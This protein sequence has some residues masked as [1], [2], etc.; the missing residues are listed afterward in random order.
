MLHM[1]KN[2]DA[3]MEQSI[4]YVR[5][6]INKKKQ[7]LIE[8]T[9]MDGS[10]DFPKP[11]KLLHLSCLKVF[12]MFF[13]ASNRFDSDTDLHDDIS[14]AIYIPLQVQS[15]KSLQKSLPLPSVSR[16]KSHGITSYKDFS[17]PTKC[18]VNRRLLVHQLS[19]T[20]LSTNG[21]CKITFPPKL[22]FCFI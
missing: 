1:R 3:D 14:K 9:L 17:C 15:P 20:T 22:N 16:A 12:Q 2:P 11:C 7:E 6:I 4:A 13:N 18:Y 19:R 21:Y 8:H 5:D 10:D